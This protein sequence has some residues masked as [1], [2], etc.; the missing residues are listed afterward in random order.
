MN[1][2]SVDLVKTLRPP[3]ARNVF[4]RVDELSCNIFIDGRGWASFVVHGARKGNV[5]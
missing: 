2:V 1:R 3:L 5:V 4:I